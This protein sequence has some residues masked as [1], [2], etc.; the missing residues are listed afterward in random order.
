MQMSNYTQ[1]KFHLGTVWGQ[2]G[3]D[4]LALP[5]NFPWLEDYAAAYIARGMD[6]SAMCIFQIQFDFHY[7]FKNI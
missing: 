6:A 5:Q 7:S 2:T 4:P 1:Q 3:D